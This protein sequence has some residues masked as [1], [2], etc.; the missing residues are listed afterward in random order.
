MQFLLVSDSLIRTG[1]FQGGDIMNMKKIKAIMEWP[2]PRN[3]D[4][5]RPAGYYRRFDKNF[6][7]INYLI[8][9]FHK[10]GGSLNGLSVQVVL[11]S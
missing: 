5:V 8:T 9:Y 6:S 4:E 1:C 11:S 7:R 2:T 10:K 3:V